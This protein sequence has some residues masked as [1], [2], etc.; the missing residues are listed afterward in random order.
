MTSFSLSASPIFGQNIDCERSTIATTT[1]LRE[2][3]PDQL[4]LWTEQQL[5]GGALSLETIQGDLP[6]AVLGEAR[7][8]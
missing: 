7:Q 5:D 4:C 2:E 3:P 1:T 6:S 8:F